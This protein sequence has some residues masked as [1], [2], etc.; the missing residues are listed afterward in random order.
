[1]AS[2]VGEDYIN[3]AHTLSDGDQEASNALY[4]EWA[5]SYD[6]HLATMDYLSPKAAVDAIVANIKEGSDLKILDAGCGTGLVGSALANNSAVSGRFKLDGIDISSGMLDEARKKGIYQ[7]LDVGDLSQR[8]QFADGSYDVVACVGTLT[9]GHVGPEAL[10]EFVR[11][12]AK[13]GLVVGTIYGKIWESHGYKGAAES[14]SDRGVAELVSADEFAI[15]EGGS[16]GGI[17]LVLRKK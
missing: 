2:T 11:V 14:L 12:A 10:E 17:M 9:M 8:L 5:S 16:R 13:G 7:S 3:K 1:M 4:N 6:A 15:V